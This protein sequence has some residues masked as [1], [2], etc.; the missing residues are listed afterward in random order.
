[1]AKEEA[2][3]DLPVPTDDDRTY[4]RIRPTDTPI[5]A[6]TVA[7]QLS[8]LHAKQLPKADAWYRRPFQSTRPTYETL[9]VSDGTTVTYYVGVESDLADSTGRLLRSLY[10]D[11]YE[12]T[13]QDWAPD[14]TL[15]DTEHLAA[16]EY[17]G[18]VERARD[19]QTKL[20]DF[21]SFLTDEHA[22][23]PLA[24]IV[25]TMADAEVPMV[26][27][28]LFRPRAEWA[29]E[30]DE[31]VLA[32][33]EQHETIGD[34]VLTAV[35]GPPEDPTL[36]VADEARVEELG[37][38]FPRRSFDVTARLAIA[39]ARNQTPIQ[40]I[41]HELADAFRHVSHTSYEVAGRVRTDSKAQRV[42]EDIRNRTAHEPSYRR[43]RKRPWRRPESRGIVMDYQELGA[44]TV[45]DGAALTDA[46]DRTVEPTPGERQ[47]LQ[48][49]PPTILDE[50]TTRGLT[51]GRP[52]T[53]DATTEPDP[54]ALPEELQPL[55]VAWF[56]KTGA[57]KSTGLTAGI[58]DNHQA[59]DGASI[60]VLPK[61]DGM[62]TDYMRA[63]YA[64][65]GHLNNVL[66]YDCSKVLPAF[67]FF[68]I[69]DQL[70]AGIPRTTAVEDSVDHY[71]E[72]LGQVMGTERFERAVR[73][74]D[75]IRYMV[76]ALY[77][78]VSG[79]DAF[80][81][82][83]LH[84]AVRQLHERQTAPA[85]SDPD[86]E[87]ML[88]G[89][90]ANRARS[91]DEIMQGVA[92]RIEK[93]PIDQRLAAIFDH[94]PQDDDPHFDLVDYLDENVVIILDTGSLRP[95]AQRVLTLLVLSNLWTA[96]RR[97]LNRSDGDPP[98]ANL[99]IEE[100]ASVA[101]SELLQELLAQARSFGC[102]VTLAMQFP[103]QLKE[104]RRIYDELLNNVSTVVTGNVPRDRE[105]AARLATDD[106][107]ARDVGNRLRALQRGQWMVKLPAAYGQPEPR[108]FTVESV[109]PPAGHPA[110]DHTPSRS[111][112]WAFQDAKLDV[113][114]RT[115][116]TAGLVLGSPSVRMGDDGETTDDAE[117]TESVDD[118]VRVDS[119]L[120]YTQRMP[121]TVTYKQSVHALQCTTC[122]NR[123]D[124]DIT[125]MKRAIS[126]CS[127]LEEVDRDDI[128]VCNLN[129]KLTPEER[130]VSEWSTEQ[131]L[132][133][134]SVYNAQ[135]LRY[136]P[137]E[138]DLLY[139]SMIRL[140]EYVGIDSGAV[141]DLIDADLLRKDSEHP[142]RLYSVSPDGRDVIGESYRQGVDYGHGAGDLEESTLH[143]LAVEVGRQYL[144]QNYVANTDSPVTETVP[145]YDIDE[146][147]RLDLAGVDD[148]GE[149]V[150]AL[151]AERVNN[152]VL[153]AAPEDFDKIADC[154]VEEAIWVVM[155][156]SDAHN[157]LGVLNDPP[158]GEP[159]VE[160][161]YSTGTPPQQF[162][163][164]TPGLTAMYPVEWLRHQ[165]EKS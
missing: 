104:D 109:A 122:E 139:D 44:L 42:L 99:Y 21:E 151:E 9:L 72:I 51:L 160:K 11:T 155:K 74:P 52:L 163:I 146:Q 78:P 58:L 141:Q 132:F 149:I 6:Q 61:G 8:R 82:R 16:V 25:E 3:P 138:Y 67:S 150:V 59:T 17:L 137:L 145:Y 46:G 56:G 93:I 34:Q 33:K 68:D 66:Y 45:V 129:L 98:L 96:L 123:Y 26:Y 124:P 12:F 144:E 87:R 110:H 136:D 153:R 125:G 62:A 73:S 55:H 157:I 43:L 142:H 105:L 47:T 121:P 95:A 89:V 120:P 40:A 128:P 118:S 69:R 161:T 127:S 36:P 70:D 85:V 107:D 100:A 101:D 49:P 32:L 15:L 5:N 92:N 164:D 81:H 60:V 10:P 80:S 30:R 35:F 48:R 19:W 119:A 91:F 41:A 23:I 103:A 71:L 97:R 13:Q 75:I 159:R 83:E 79:D 116:D 84:A 112:E 64:K 53:E 90:T 20:T 86:L 148:D 115:L 156:Q 154:D 88:A 2:N 102:S 28:V 31:R 131:L 130:A 57:G 143:V 134:Q 126:C 140:Q 37:E 1:M 65:Y 29:S 63:H 114:E 24:T 77:D 113:H 76:K 108:P 54:I 152:D 18:Q 4:I 7:T 158:E 135:Q 133:L 14:R 147:R 22:R 39:D 27:Q 117:D 162:R 165:L 94:V 106:M 38:R 50:Y 111:E